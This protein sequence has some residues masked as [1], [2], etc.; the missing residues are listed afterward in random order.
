[1]RL[2]RKAIFAI[3]AV[4]LAF[5]F[6]WSAVSAQEGCFPPPAGL[7]NWWPGDG[8]ADDIVGGRHGFLRFGATTGLGLVDQAFLLHGA[9][10]I[11]G[12]FVRVPDDPA[13]DFGTGDFTVDLWVFF[14]DPGTGE[15]VLIEKW[16][17]VFDGPSTG[18][19]LT[20]LESNEIRFAAP[21]HDVT[22]SPLAIRAGTWIHFA[23]TRSAGV[24]TIF[25]NGR[26]IASGFV[27]DDLNSSSSIKF[28]MRGDPV[29]TPGSQDTRGFFLSGGIDE[30]EIFV[31][32]ALPQGVIRAIYQAGS[33]GKCKQV[34]GPAN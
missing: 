15:Q 10:P 28:G 13:L 22:L 2:T 29:N 4:I 17:Q 9:R 14:S 3:G 25:I 6:T 1:M 21:E 7:T 20:K 31:G 19:T 24:V 8:N 23:V 11:A 12:D 32:V 30:V 16:I 33:R 26:A 18:W 34:P 27:P 5:A